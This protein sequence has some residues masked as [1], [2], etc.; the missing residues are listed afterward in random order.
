MD[1]YFY[2]KYQQEIPDL[3][4]T[5]FVKRTQQSP[6]ALGYLSHR[7]K[8]KHKK[9]NKYNKKKKKHN[10]NKETKTNKQAKSQNRCSH[11]FHAGPLKHELEVHSA[12]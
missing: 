3:L 6:A 4:L 11:N 1:W 2:H 7:H 9:I 8:N 12:V 10:K 5:C